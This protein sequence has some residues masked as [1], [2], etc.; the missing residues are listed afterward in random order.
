MEENKMEVR[1]EQQEVMEPLKEVTEIV[2]IQVTCIGK[3]MTETGANNVFLC[4]DDKA[5][6][7]RRILKNVFEADDVTV[8]I[9]YFVRDQKVEEPATDDEVC[10]A[11]KISGIE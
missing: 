10:E 1:E 4:R 2:H 9:Q 6:D 3:N 7:I 11:C 5:E 8:Q